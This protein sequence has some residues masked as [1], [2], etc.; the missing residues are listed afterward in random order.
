MRKKHQSQTS[1]DRGCSNCFSNVNYQQQRGTVIT[2]IEQGR[3]YQKDFIDFIVFSSTLVR[4]WTPFWTA[5][6]LIQLHVGHG[7]RICGVKC[8]AKKG[9]TL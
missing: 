7:G 1:Q 5:V 2:R 3:S 8:H 6:L 4:F 9:Y